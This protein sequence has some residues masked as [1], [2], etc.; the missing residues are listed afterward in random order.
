MAAAPDCQ[1][2][3]T[4][5]LN[6]VHCRIKAAL[7]DASISDV[8]VNTVDGFQGREKEVIVISTVRSNDTRQ[9]GFL[10]DKRRMN[11]AVTRARRQCI[12]I[13]NSETL[14]A[15]AF[16]RGLVEHFQEHGAYRSAQEVLD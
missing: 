8:E 1:I 14:Q 2:A 3:S 5:I 15:D 4:Q 10:A 12:L 9:V 11:V 13:G 16:L 6:C 7:A